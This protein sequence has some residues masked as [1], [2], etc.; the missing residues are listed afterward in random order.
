[1]GICRVFKALPVHVK[2]PFEQFSIFAS[3]PC[4]VDS[5]DH[6]HS[7]S[8]LNP[9]FS[10]SKVCIT[11]LKF[12]SLYSTLL[13]SRS[14]VSLCAAVVLGYHKTVA[15][16]LANYGTMGSAAGGGTFLESLAVGR[17]FRRTTPST[18]T[19]IA[20]SKRSGL[21]PGILIGV[22]FYQRSFPGATELQSLW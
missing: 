20:D 7:N 10:R 18:Y 4:N 8:F 17:S 22:V 6:E 3:F 13:A 14:W 19:A 1:M 9:N 12:C 5:S 2:P 15:S 16:P 11:F 21:A